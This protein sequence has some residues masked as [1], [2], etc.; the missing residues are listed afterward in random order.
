MDVG[1][2]PYWS[3]QIGPFQWSKPVLVFRQN[4]TDVQTISILDDYGD[5]IRYI[6]NVAF[7]N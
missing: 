1:L 5:P 6:R 3:L 4:V 2:W 7:V